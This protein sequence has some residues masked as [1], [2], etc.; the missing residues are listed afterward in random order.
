[1]GETLFLTK[2]NEDF[3][4]V[5]LTKNKDDFDDLSSLLQTNAASFAHSRDTKSR[6]QTGGKVETRR[7]DPSP[8]KGCEGF[9]CIMQYVHLP[10]DSY[11]W[12]DT[13]Y[14]MNGTGSM[15]DT[16]FGEP[17]GVSQV[18]WT[19]YVLNVTSQTW[20]N[21]EVSHPV[22]WHLLTVVIPGNRRT[23]DWAI[24]KLD[25]G[26]NIAGLQSVIRLDNRVEGGFGVDEN[27]VIEVSGD[28]LDK[29]FGAVRGAAQKAA[30]LAIKTGTLAASLAQVPN[31]YEVFR[32]DPYQMLRSSDP[33]RG[34]TYSN[35]L[36]HPDHPEMLYELLAAKAV[37]RAMDTITS[38]CGAALD[39]NISRFVL[40]G[41]S[42]LG[43]ATFVAGAV[44]DR[45][46]AIVPGNTALGM[47]SPASSAS[48][49]PDDKKAVIAAVNFSIAPPANTHQFLTHYLGISVAGVLGDPAAEAM[50]NIIDA[51]AW[52]WRITKPMLLI[53]SDMEGIVHEEASSYLGPKLKSIVPNSV[54]DSAFWKA[55]PSAAAFMK[56]FMDDVVPPNISE[57][58]SRQDTSLEVQQLG[59]HTPVMVQQ[60]ESHDCPICWSSSLLQETTPGSGTWRAVAASS[61]HLRMY[62]LLKYE[63]PGPGFELS[64][65]SS[66]YP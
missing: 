8:I 56:G 31:G 18:A 3:E 50:H 51:S 54:H 48:W 11:H 41:Y 16:A 13:G 40:S 47:L 12:E 37:V 63:W 43:S 33:L 42:K 34:Y 52:L 22:Q 32:D 25:F 60:W 15:Y 39:Y 62:V 23:S 5:C 38:F 55:L 17:A 28:N 24:L 36:L 7:F 66:T 19:G 45:V 2:N 57:A 49:S 44:D 21:H 53:S 35:F 58:Y 27:P 4:A 61:N 30:Y 14:R 65:T 59:N 46:K 6:G 29:Q 9:D 10:D 64:I 26:I 20:L 1:V